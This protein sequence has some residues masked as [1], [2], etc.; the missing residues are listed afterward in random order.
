MRTRQEK[1]HIDFDPSKPLTQEEAEAIFQ[2]GKEAVVFVLLA[3]SAQIIHAQ[4]SVQEPKPETPSGMIPPYQK[5]T[6]K[7]KRKKRGA[8]RGHGGSSRNVA[9]ATHHHEH[10]PLTV[11]P[12]CGTQLGQPVARR[13][14]QIEDIIETKPEITDHFIPRTWC[15]HCHKIVEPPV[16]DALPNGRF[17]HRLL[18]LTMWLH[19]GLGVTIA[20]IVTVL[21]VHLHFHISGGGLVKN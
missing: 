7:R 8:K 9:E 4:A 5:K 10:D 2:L 1:P 13:T 12:D 3:L 18:A 20:H 11:C 17:G 6:T 16:S 15:P 21:K 14:R 19:F